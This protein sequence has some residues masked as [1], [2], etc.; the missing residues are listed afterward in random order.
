MFAPPPSRVDFSSDVDVDL[1]P[2]MERSVR[3]SGLRRTNF[4]L[5]SGIIITA[6]VCGVC[7]WLSPIVG[8]LLL[9]L[10]SFFWFSEFSYSRMTPDAMNRSSISVLES[11][12]PVS[13]FEILP[14]NS[15][16]ILENFFLTNCPEKYSEINSI[17][18]EIILQFEAA[19]DY[20]RDNPSLRRNLQ[21]I[22]E[23]IWT[24]SVRYSN[25]ED[26][27]WRDFLIRLQNAAGQMTQYF[28]RCED[29][30]VEG[31]Y[32]FQMD[33]ALLE[34]PK[35][36]TVEESFPLLWNA[37][38]YH[39]I[40]ELFGKIDQYNSGGEI[41]EAKL[42][43]MKILSFLSNGYVDTNVDMYYCE[44]GM[45]ILVKIGAVCASGS[46]NGLSIR[47]LMVPH[48]FHFKSGMWNAL[49]GELWALLRK[50]FSDVI[51]QLSWNDR[52]A[53]EEFV[54]M[55][56]AYI[57]KR[58]T[59]A[60]MRDYYVGEI[61]LLG[62]RF[63]GQ[64][65]R[66]YELGTIFKEGSNGASLFPIIKISKSHGDYDRYLSLMKEMERIYASQLEPNELEIINKFKESGFEKF[67][68]SEYEILYNLLNFF[69]QM[70]NHSREELMS[71]LSELVTKDGRGQ[72]ALMDEVFMAEL[73]EIFPQEVGKMHF[74][75]PF[76]PIIEIIE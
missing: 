31:M 10:H 65:I 51:R 17:V 44:Y 53:A 5:L 41:V 47:R 55:I 39:F 19:K 1:S 52:K 63:F 30:A 24:L 70:K 73:E 9:G 22:I 33:I 7:L 64:K 15:R 28:D 14:K 74:L 23:K 50:E 18:N 56:V 29:A 20:V 59:V 21:R 37:Y 58:N 61:R 27:D 4:F 36:A 35:D 67:T 11:R 16:E 49:K 43:I 75:S 60:A 42:T 8:L 54:A 45:Q 12:M 57:Q 48:N 34:L 3:G 6:T 38:I 68:I 66:E 40:E 72:L 26:E 62:K 25:S 13:E 2:D 46:S 32:A 71:A 76:R 69:D